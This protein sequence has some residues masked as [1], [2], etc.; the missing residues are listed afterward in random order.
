MIQVKKAFWFFSLRVGA[1][2]VGLVFLL[3]GLVNVG[4]GIFLPAWTW[5]LPL[6]I[7]EILTSSSLLVGA[8][9]REPIFVLPILVWI[10]VDLV[11]SVILMVWMTGWMSV[12]LAIIFPVYGYIWLCQFSFWKQMKDSTTLADHSEALSVVIS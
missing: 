11:I 6:G 5:A 1:Y 8:S 9:K 3:L 12:I 7:L 10:P 2:I 4:I